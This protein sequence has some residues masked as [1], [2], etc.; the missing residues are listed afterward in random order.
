[1]AIETAATLLERERELTELADALTDAQRGRGRVVLVEAPAGLGKTSLLEGGRRDRRRG[2]LHVPARARQRARARLRLRLRAAAAR[3]RRREGRRTPSASACSRAP[4]PSRGRSSPRPGA[5]HA[6]VL[7]RQLVLDAARPLLA[8]QQPRRRA[9]PSPCRSTT[10]TGPTRSRCD[11]STTWPRAWTA[12]RSPS[13]PP[14]AAARRSRRTW[15]GWPPPPRRRCCG[16]RPLSIEATATLC[17]RR[18]GDGRGG[19]VRGGLP[20]GHRRQPLLPRGA[21]AR[22]RASRGSSTDAREAARV[23]AHRPRRRGPGGAPAPLERPAAATAL[24]RA[25]AV[26]G[27]GAGL[28]EAA[29]LAGLAEDEA[30]RAADLLVALA[31]LK[32]RRAPRVRAPDRA[33]GRLRGH[34]PARARPGA[35]PRGRDPRPSGRVRGADRGPDRRG[36]A[37]RRPRAG[38]APAPGGRGRARSGA[39]GRRRRLARPGAGGAAAARVPGGGAA[40]A[41]LG[42]APPRSAGGG[43]PPHGGGRAD[44]GAGAARGL[45]CACWRTR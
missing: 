29:R 33:G 37:G 28:A 17:E 16:P 42:G 43:R 18:L 31:I 21:P 6:P 2:G 14:R 1:M 8:A 39:P 45:R 12:S 26:L 36:G 41:R 23:R 19:R 25:V 27:D 5:A 24:V 7:G 15:P 40:R 34:R 9:A 13:S 20:R 3:A 11:S 30:A 35:R 32:P 4:R 44:P 22:G 10:S 38:R